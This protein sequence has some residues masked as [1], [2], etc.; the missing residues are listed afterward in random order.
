MLYF[1][2]GSDRDA[3]RAALNAAVEKTAGPQKGTFRITDAHTAD[4][5]RMALQGPGMFPP[6]GGRAGGGRVVVFDGILGGNNEEAQTIFLDSLKSMRDSKELFFLLEGSLDA[7]VRKQVEKYAEESKRFDAKK[8]ER[9]NAIFALANYLQR[10]DKKN[11]W[12][13]LMREFEKG[14][15]P[16]A[17]HGLLFW[18]AK[19]GVLRSRGGQEAQR[20]RRLMAALAELPHVA[21]RKGEDLSY[22]LERFALSSV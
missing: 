4:D 9:D 10:G 6:A 16:E 11:L 21:R 19:Q 3:A 13:G 20:A 14:A 7:A 15:A 17:V 12:I 8:G 22:A 18:A 1:F 2:S 5:L